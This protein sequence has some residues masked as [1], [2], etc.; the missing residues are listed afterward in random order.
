MIWVL[1]LFFGWNY[2]TALRLLHE[3]D[4]PPAINTPLVCAVPFLVLLLLAGSV[5]DVVDW[6]ISPRR[7]SP[8]RIRGSADHQAAGEAAR[9]CHYA[10]TDRP[11]S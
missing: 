2:V 9:R 10:R 3:V 5:I 11:E 8:L 1:F 6:A 4:E 7:P